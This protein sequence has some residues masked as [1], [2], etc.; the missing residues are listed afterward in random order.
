MW[1]QTFELAPG[2]LTP[3]VNP[4]AR[5]L[6]QCQL[7]ERLAG[8][9]V[10]DIG[11][12]NG[13]VC[14]EAERRGASA[15]VGLDLTPPS[16]CGFDEIREFL[17]SKARFVRGSVYELPSLL[18]E[19]FDIVFFLGVL[20]HL[21]HPLLALDVLRS[22]TREYALIE[23]QVADAELQLA[24]DVPV[25]RFYRAGELGGDP[26][27]WFAPSLSCL[28]DWCHSCGLSPELLATWPEPRPARCV[29]R[30]TPTGD[31]PEYQ[32]LSYEVP[33]VTSVV[34]PR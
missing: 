27:N 24:T 11:T 2:V 6:T 20:Y 8:K 10:L 32:T 33:L 31:V 1:W 29:V 5:L 19:R 30:V 34:A 28:V 4:I 17:G 16:H 13:A 9:T 21:R 3:G 12:A 23:T 25:A 14:F 22:V 18:S 7:P 15:V 26:T